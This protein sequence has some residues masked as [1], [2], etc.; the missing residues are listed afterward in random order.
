MKPSPLGKMLLLMILTAC[1]T[2]PV[3]SA[4]P[5][6][7]TLTPTGIVQR[8]SSQTP[9]LTPTQ[10]YV[11]KGSWVRYTAFDWTHDGE[12]YEGEHVRIFADRARDQDKARFAEEAEKSL[13]FVQEFLGIADEEIR[14]PQPQGKIDIYASSTHHSELEG[15]WAYYGGFLFDYDRTIFIRTSV[16]YLEDFPYKPLFDHE[17]THTV[18]YLVEGCGPDGEMLSETWFHEGVAVYL[19]QNP[20]FRIDTLSQ[21]DTM[22]QTLADVPGGGNPIL[23]STW[24]DIPAYYFD[25]T[26]I[27][28][29]YSLFELAT[30]Y[31]VDTF[32]VEQFRLIFLDIHAG[33]SFEEAFANHYGMSV[34]EYQKSFFTRMENYLP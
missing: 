20:P 25:A 13:A 31:L 6:E 11:A 23:I 18:E 24:E 8:I 1:S 21:L 33:S 5:L 16:D 4:L 2:A 30:H 22:R 7:S 19:S 26:N 14:Y 15:G 17:M 27:H 34:A 3:Q 10:R 29:L 32:G 28:N 12:P 9:H